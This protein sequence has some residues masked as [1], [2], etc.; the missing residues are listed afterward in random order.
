MTN[1]TIAQELTKQLIGRVYNI[2]EA[3]TVANQ[4]RDKCPS[5]H[6]DVEASGQFGR[7]TVYDN[8]HNFLGVY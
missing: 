7:V 3:K 6:F 5:M 2:A 1:T 8:V 4:L